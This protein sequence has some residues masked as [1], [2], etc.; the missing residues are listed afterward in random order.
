MKKILSI[1][2]CAII[3]ICSYGQIYNQIVYLD[4]YDD[5]VL[6]EDIKTIIE[7][8]DSTFIIDTK[9]KTPEKYYI[10]NYAD[11][12]SLGSKDEIVNLTGNV[13]GYQESWCVIKSENL[14]DYM[15]VLYKVYDKELP[16]EYLQK[17]WLFITHRVITTQYTHTYQGEYFWIED[18]F[19]T[20][21]GKDINRIIYVK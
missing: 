10:L 7:K 9:G 14:K 13:Y 15:Y 6:K 17:Y 21:L 8:T 20:Q 16:T 19:N 1:V 4:K 18:E 3:C 2:I 12:N 5:V 11:Y